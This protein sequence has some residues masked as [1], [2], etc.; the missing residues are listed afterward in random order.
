MRREWR[1]HFPRHCWL[2]I[3]TCITAHAWH[4]PWCISGSLTSGFLWSQWWGIR[5]RHSRRMRNPQFYV[6][7][8]DHLTCGYHTQKI[9]HAKFP[10]SPYFRKKNNQVT[11]VWDDFMFSVNF[12]HSRVR[13]LSDFRLSHQYRLSYI[14]DIYG[15]EYIGLAKCT[16]MT[17]PWPCPKVTAVIGCYFDANFLSKFRMCFF[18]GQALFKPYLRNGWSD[19]CETK[20]NC[21]SW[22][23]GIICDLDL[24]PHS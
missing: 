8:I 23:L 6:S 7:A 1:E 17:L 9:P 4:V 22:T 2:V 12:R 13:R 19:W 14:L 16:G 11:P 21:I 18:Q 24:W 3:L 20:R 10:C 15:K 5:S